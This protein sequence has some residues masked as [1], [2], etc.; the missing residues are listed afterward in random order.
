MLITFSYRDGIKRLNQKQEDQDRDKILSRLSTI[1]PTARQSEAFNSHQK[2]TGKWLWDAEEFQ[3]WINNS[4][5]VLFCPGIPGAGKTVLSSIMIDYIDQKFAEVEDVGLTYLFYDYR[6]RPT[7]LKIYCALLQQLLLG[8]FSITESIKLF[9][10]N[11][12]QKGS[13]P[14]EEQVLRELKSIVA[15]CTR[16]FIVIDALDECPI[17]NGVQSVRHPFIRQLLSR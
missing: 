13:R 2:G 6:Q 5:R 16:T 11:Y 7:L 10:E 9:Y 4:G 14:N 17:S 8:M 3:E 1:I 12:L 15:S